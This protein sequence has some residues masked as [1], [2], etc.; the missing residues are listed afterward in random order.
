MKKVNLLYAG[1]AIKD[2]MEYY[3]HEECS[4][5]LFPVSLKDENGNDV[6]KYAYV[7]FKENNREEVENDI[8]GRK[9]HSISEFE[10]N[11]ASGCLIT[12]CDKDTIIDDFISLDSDDN[13]LQFMIPDCDE[14]ENIND[15]FIELFRIS[16]SSIVPEDD[17]VQLYMSVTNGFEPVNSEYSSDKGNSSLG[18]KFLK[19][20]S[21]PFGKKNVDK[22]E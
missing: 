21:N 3:T 22:Y 17:V 9:G 8:K 10:I 16:R 20:L 19:L 1:L 7:A 15:F 4:V 11:P 5:D 2:L 14:Y 13:T 12:L 18:K 6:I